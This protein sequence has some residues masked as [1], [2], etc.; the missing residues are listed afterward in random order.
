ML[1]TSTI[2]SNPEKPTPAAYLPASERTSF[3]RLVGFE[4]STETTR[5][6]PSGVELVLYRR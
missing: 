3:R 1:S 4:E 2:A 5:C 6:G